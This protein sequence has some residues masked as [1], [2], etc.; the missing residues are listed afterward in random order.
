LSDKFS[1]HKA[2]SREVIAQ[3]GTD[4]IGDVLAV[5][6]NKVPVHFINGKFDPMVPLETLADYKADY[7][8][9]DYQTHSDAGQLIFFAKWREVFPLLNK[10]L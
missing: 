3:A 10:Y 9:I 8:W 5:R 7:D 6:D 1:A 2:F 4:W